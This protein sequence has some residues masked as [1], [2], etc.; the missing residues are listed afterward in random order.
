MLLLMGLIRMNC[1]AGQPVGINN[2]SVAKWLGR[3]PGMLV[4]ACLP[5]LAAGCAGAPNQAV[6]GKYA[7][8]CAEAGLSGRLDV[9]EKACTREMEDAGWNT[10]GAEQKS[11]K[12]YN[13]ARIKEQLSKYPEAE[14]LLR[15]SLA[16]EERLSPP[17]PLRIVRRLIAL[18]VNVAAQQRWERGVYY[19]D[20]AIPLA[21][22][23][24]A[25]ERAYLSR[26]LSQ[27]ARKLREWNQVALAERYEAAATALR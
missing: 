10:L 24:P 4:I 27:Y 25:Q 13:L 2:P 11:Q 1:L 16:V 22:E 15:A 17:S 8:A 5:V 20:R 6:P 19:L 3:I 9:A 18:A 7:T 26:V 14:D 21:P 23:L 12:L